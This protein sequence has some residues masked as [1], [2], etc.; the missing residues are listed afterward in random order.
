MSQYSE[1]ELKQLHN[2]LYDIMG[3]VKRVCN[4]LNIPYF[5]IGGTGIGIHF[6][7]AIIPW[8]DD[9]DIGMTRENYERFLKEAPAVLRKGYFL[10]WVETDIHTPFYF[11]KVR[12][13]GTLFIEDTTKHLDIHHGIFVDIFPMDKVPD[14]PRLQK[15]QRTISKY[16][17][18]A[19][20]AKDVWLWRHCGKPMCENPY[21][22]NA[23]YCFLFKGFVSLFSKKQLYAMFTKSVAFFNNRKC[24][25]CN[26]VLMT[27]DH[28]AM[29]SV[30]NLEKRPFGPLTISAPSNLETY[31]RHHYPRLRKDLPKE[32]QVNHRPLELRF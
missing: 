30:E 21:N 16:L 29:Q 12:R 26:I 13:D 32:E 25:Y 1:K 15:L 7:K 27:R 28:I 10:Q 19:F 6:Y 22:W 8:D 11:A 4:L 24:Q 3:E 9:I 18:L 20:I 23:F 14:N 31:L 5:A 2:V 17:N